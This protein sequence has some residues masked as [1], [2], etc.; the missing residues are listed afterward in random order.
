MIDLETLLTYHQGGHTDLQMD[1]FITIR[2]G[3]TPYGCFV[4]ALR[5]LW[6]RSRGLSD[7]TCHRDL[8]LIDIDELREKSQPDSFDGRRA[9]IHL[10]QKQKQLLEVDASLATNRREFVRFY[11]Q[12][13]S[14]FVSLGFDKSPPDRETIERLD[15]ERWEHVVRCHIALDLYTQKCVSR[16]SA[17][18]LQSFP[19][20]TRERI[21]RECLS[22][23]AAMKSCISWYMD[24]RPEIPQSLVVDETEIGRLLECCESLPL[25]K[26]LPSSSPMEP[27]PSVLGNTATDSQRANPVRSGAA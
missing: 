23:D 4:Q 15:A 22:S 7:D 20:E 18:L 9:K 17:E 26:R 13:V 8:L 10:R 19:I 24:Y 1:H 16:S 21:G 5:E 14:L 27:M 3:G 2:S 25:P 12:A 11:G 6:K